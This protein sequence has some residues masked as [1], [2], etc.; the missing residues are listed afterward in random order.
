MR[1]LLVYAKLCRGIYI[2]KLML[3]NW[4][5]YKVYLGVKHVC[6]KYVTWS[7]ALS[8]F[9]ISIPI[10]LC[11][12]VCLCIYNK[13]G[14]DQCP[15]HR[16]QLCSCYSLLKP[17]YQLAKNINSRGTI[18]FALR[19]NSA[20]W[21]FLGFKYFC[22]DSGMLPLSIISFN[23][24]TRT[25]FSFEGRFFIIRSNSGAVFLDSFNISYLR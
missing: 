14:G 17:T 5:I 22:Q 13:I 23:A 4:F 1:P 3:N 19:Q 2:V 24:V 6:P 9:A 15:W 7:N 12:K 18:L 10:I 16:Y 11:F 21:F 20:Q 8:C 25:I